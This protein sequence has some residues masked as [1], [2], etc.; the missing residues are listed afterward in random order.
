MISAITEKRY[1]CSDEQLEAIHRALIQEFEAVSK[2][3]Q[4]Q[5]I[6]LYNGLFQQILADK[7]LYKF[8][9]PNDPEKAIEAD[10]PYILSIDG[11]AVKG[12]VYS[13]TEQ[14]VEIE[15]H[16][17]K[18]RI[19]PTL[20]IIIDLRILIDLIDRRIVSIDKEPSKFKLSSAK[21]LFNPDSF[22]SVKPL[23]L[24]LDHSNRND[25]L[26]LNDDQLNAIKSSLER[27]LAVIWGPPG[28]G[29]TK[30]LQ[31]VIAEMLMNNKKVLFAS[32]TN[33]AI[34]SL[35]KGLINLEKSP[36]G[37]F[38]R[39][40]REGKIIR[41]GSQTNDLIKEVFSPHAVLEKKSEKIL[42]ELEDYESQLEESITRLKELESELTSFNRSSDLKKE[43]DKIRRE[44]SKIPLE[45]KF[46][47]KI[48]Q[49]K[50]DKD[51]LFSELEKHDF[52]VF[53]NVDKLAKMATTLKILK[54]KVSGIKILINRIKKDLRSIE[55][56]IKNLTQEY[57]NLRMGFFREIINRKKLADLT[58]LLNLE[59]EKQKD[60][61]SNLQ[62]YKNKQKEL[63]EEEALTTGQYINRFKSR[64][65]KILLFP[66][67]ST[68][69]DK[70]LRT[71]DMSLSVGVQSLSY[72][73]VL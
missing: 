53:T 21:F 14:Y 71:F 10:K 43:L 54:E 70:L 12:G 41:L 27:K 42:I 37:I 18:G 47:V 32:N 38:S 36:Y 72:R 64:L 49:I 17:N 30:S 34:D 35:L 2:K 29:K 19:I 24:L 25:D 7:Y 16:E 58:E 13:I 44:M 5:K 48:K 73:I 28:T 40:R 23:N 11:K 1:L 33:N 52:S 22:I 3:Q 57:E 20:D 65:D 56:S 59:N 66:V 46:L 31:G 15:L 6:R 55:Q 9:T 39:L 26:S 50:N 63:I 62:E 68:L 67:D 45:D 61:L 4:E 60:L 51:L 69:I 8:E